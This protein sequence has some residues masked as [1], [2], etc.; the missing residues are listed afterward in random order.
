MDK[1]NKREFL[2]TTAFLG[3]AP[4]LLSENT[5]VQASVP[6]EAD[7]ADGRFHSDS[8][9]HFGSQAIHHGEMNGYQVTPIIQDKCAPAGYQRP[10]NLRNQRWPHS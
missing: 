7:P 8:V 3:A 10:G 4:P 5:A 1:L 9:W 6:T 2:K